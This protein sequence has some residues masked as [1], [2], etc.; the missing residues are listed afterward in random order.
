MIEDNE[1]DIFLTMEALADSKIINHISVIKDGSEAIAFFEKPRDQERIPDL[2]L[3]DINLPRKSG[4]DVLV[5]L[6]NDA[7]YRHIP[8]IMLTTSSS[9]ADIMTAYKNHVNCFITK[10]IDAGEFVDAAAK[11]EGFWI[12]IVTLPQN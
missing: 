6:K 8:V 7:R 10:P 2:I 9:Q 5:F 4:H 1:G 11:I 3:L 12:N